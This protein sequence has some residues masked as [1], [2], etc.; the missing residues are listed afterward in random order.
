MFFES[1]SLGLGTEL[2]IVVIV[3]VKAKQAICTGRMQYQIDD[4]KREYTNT[5]IYPIMAFFLCS[6]QQ[7]HAEF[8]RLSEE[9]KTTMGALR[10]SSVNS[11]FLPLF[12][13][14]AAK[15]PPTDPSSLLTLAEV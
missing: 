12:L 8:L 5:G 4:F 6:A 9:V 11:A 13:K 3:M 1:L 14:T 15:L 2:V 7:V 10:F